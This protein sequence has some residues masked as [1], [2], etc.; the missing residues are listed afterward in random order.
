M[1][2]ELDQE[3]RSAAFGYVAQISNG[4]ERAITWTELQAFRYQGQRVPLVGQQGIFKPAAMRL[5]ISIRTTFRAPGVPRPYEDAEDEDGYLLYRYRGTDPNNYDNVWLRQVLREGLPLL[6]FFGVAKGIYQPNTAIIVEDRPSELAVLV[7]LLP[8]VSA[9]TIPIGTLSLDV[10]ARRHYLTLAKRRAGQEIFRR[11]VLAAYQHQCSLC[12]LRHSELL[13]AAHIIPDSEGGPL[14]VNN[15]LS[16]CKIHHAAYDSNIVGV[17]PDHKV[18]VRADILE[19][20]DG[21]M[22][23]YGLQELHDQTIMLP[24]RPTQHPDRL[25]LERRYERFRSAS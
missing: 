22:L 1:V 17:R 9:L 3:I 20:I 15:G 12:R 7:E 24:R 5:P 25:A 21:P 10:Q 23:R 11:S 14:V 18:E 2:A 13:D 8:V 6:Y 4:G 19:E 16:M